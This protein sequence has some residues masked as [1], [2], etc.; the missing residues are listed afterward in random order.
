MI[1]FLLA[2]QDG[3][4][5]R[6]WGSSYEIGLL[7]GTVVIVLVFIV[8]EWWMKDDAMIP[9][10]IIGSRDIATAAIANFGI[11]ASYFSAAIFLPV[12]FQLNGSSSIRSG[13]QLL[14]LVSGWRV[15]LKQAQSADCCIFQQ[16]CG[17]IFSVTSEYTRIYDDRRVTMLTFDSVSGGSMPVVGYIQP[18]MYVGTVFAVVGSGLFQLFKESTGQ[19][20]WVGITFLYGLGIG[21]CF[22]APFIYSQTCGK[23]TN[24]TEVGS[25]VTIFFQTL[26]GALIVGKST[27]SWSAILRAS[28][29]Y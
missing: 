22:Q 29:H 11:G 24:E 25:S 17:V 27:G 19:A 5:H 1:T 3:G 10:R 28:G 18:F 4:I 2:M 8:N 23:N 20:L 14:P 12:Y 21:T 6:E 15:S 13:V 7:V 26:G 16:V 9:L